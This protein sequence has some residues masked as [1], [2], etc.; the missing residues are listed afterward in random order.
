MVRFLA[1]TVSGGVITADQPLAGSI[2]L[3]AVPAV[4]Q[5]AVEK[6]VIAGLHL[7]V[8]PR[9]A[10]ENGRDPLGVS[11]CLITA[12]GVI[13]T[14]QLVRTRDY[15]QATILPRCWVHSNVATH[16]QG[17]YTPFWYQ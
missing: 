10:L 7:D 11:P 14:T 15:L 8:E 1:R 6:Q 4:E 13:D 17:P 3:V 2:T 5:V 12:Q 16:Q 9:Q